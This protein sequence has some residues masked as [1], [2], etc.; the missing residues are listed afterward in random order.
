MWMVGIVLNPMNF[1]A[2]SWDDLYVSKTL[3]YIGLLMAANMTWIHEV[4]HYVMGGCTIA[5][6]GTTFVIG[7]LIAA[8]AVY[9]MRRQVGIYPNN[10]M[11]RMI[12][13]H[14]TALTTTTRLIE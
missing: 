14:S 2:Y 12:P 10:W 3:I 9:L 8:L 1:L 13:H 6:C 7:V 4:I 5:E 11:R